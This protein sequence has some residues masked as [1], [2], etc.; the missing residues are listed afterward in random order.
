MDAQEEDHS[1]LLLGMVLWIR[2]IELV[3]TSFR[4]MRSLPTGQPVW[5]GLGSS[6]ASAIDHGAGD[7]LGRQRA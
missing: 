2:Q 6:R 4:T 3:G 5:L 7:G 1:L